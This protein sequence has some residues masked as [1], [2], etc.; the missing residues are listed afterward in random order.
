VVQN[1][2]PTTDLPAVVQ[3]SRRDVEWRR[4]QV[5][6]EMEA[7]DWRRKQVLRGMEARGFTDGGWHG[8]WRMNSQPSHGAVM[9]PPYHRYVPGPREAS[10]PGLSNY[11]APVER[12]TSFDQGLSV[13]AQHVPMNAASLTRSGETEYRVPGHHQLGVPGLSPHSTP[14][15]RAILTR[16]GEMPQYRVSGHQYHVYQGGPPR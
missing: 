1:C 12:V 2:L 14:V 7:R 3:L 10:V 6:Q 5:I 16:N 4:E 11:S 9:P 13:R 8:S 15:E